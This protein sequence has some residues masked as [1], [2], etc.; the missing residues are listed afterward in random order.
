LSRMLSARNSGSAVSKSTLETEG[1]MRG[2]R[3][4]RGQDR[5]NLASDCERPS[6]HVPILASELAASDGRYGRLSR[7]DAPGDENR[8]TK[9]KDLSQARS[10]PVQAGSEEKAI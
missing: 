1:C 9:R 8:G 7:G 3:S 2:Q 5:F 10:L 4:A 6:Q